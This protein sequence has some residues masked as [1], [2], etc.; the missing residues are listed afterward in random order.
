MTTFF[1]EVQTSIES[2]LDAQ[3]GENTYKVESS[4]AKNTYWKFTADKNYL[5]KVSPL[6]GSSNVPTV[7]TSVEGTDS[8]TLGGAGLKYPSK[9]YALEKGKTYYFIMNMTGESGFKLDLSEMYSY[10]KGL[11][12]ENP[13]ELKLGEE[14]YL[15]NPLGAQYESTTAYITY[16]A[17]KTAQLQI[18]FSGYVPNATVNGTTVTTYDQTTGAY[19][20]KA[21][22]EKGQTYSIALNLQG[23]VVANSKL[24]E[25]K[26]GS[27]EMPFAL[28]EG[29]NKVPAEMGDYYFTYTPTKTGYLNIS[30]DAVLAGGQVKV[31]TSLSNITYQQ[32]AASSEAGTYNVRVEI[33]YTGS[34]YYIVVNKLQDSATEDV[35]KAEMQD[36]QPGE[37]VNTAFELTELPVE[38]TLPSAK[39]T[40]YYKLTV[41]ANTEMFVTVETDATLDAATSILFYNQQNGEYGAATVKDGL[42]KTYVGGQSYDITYILKVTANEDNP[43]AFKVS[44]LDVEKGSLVTN[45]A[46]A[47]AG[48]NEITIEGTEYFK[49]TATKDGKLNVEVEP[50]VTVSFPRGTG[51]WDGEYNAINKGT[52][53]FIEA[54]AG[55]TYLIKVSGAAEGTTMYLE[56][57]EFSAG[58]SRTN[59]IVMEGDEY[60]LTKAG[61]ADLWLQYNVTEDGVLD[62]AC[63]HG[64]N[65]GSDRIEIIKNQE[66]YGTTMMGTETVGNVSTTVFKGKVTVSK[67]DKLYI[68]C[69]LAGQVTGSKIKFT[70][71][72]AEP[73]ETVTNPLVITK[74]KTVTITGASRSTPVWLKASLPAGKTTFRLSGYLMTSLYNSLEDAK[75]GANAEEVRTNY[76]QMPD[77]SYVYEFTKDMAEAGDVYFQF[78]DSYGATGFT[79]MDDDATG[80]WNIEAAGDSK[81]SIFKMDGTQVNQIPG[82]GVY[83]IKS[84]GKTKK[85][86]IKK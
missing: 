23:G 75:N 36:Y 74:G 9:A 53:F 73:G 68:H 32:V 50:G 46:E 15:G 61:A 58:E 4:E 13:A 72:E 8:L 71:H 34:T 81:V 6:S 56:E 65:G 85:V 76:V 42:L 37:T 20:L 1:R 79:W 7:F 31:Y 66:P 40:Y 24:V 78:V 25:V 51:Q 11:S 64:Y 86:I 27:L 69:V 47:V 39:G 55:T 12:Q 21:S 52:D 83:I 45:P 49:Y 3:K 16:T 77:G 84:N 43:L 33:P 60:T 19:M 44:Y 17:E 22:V 63:D 35:I 26:A 18:S 41:P 54:T 5:A 30:S 57:K 80:I 14:L 59:P 2:A 28:N 67:G 82:N 48:E 62:F 10:G 38:N 29:E 70:K